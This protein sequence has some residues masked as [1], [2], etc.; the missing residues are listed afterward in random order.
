MILEEIKNIKSEKRDLRNFGITFGVVL[1]LI[2]GLLWWKEKDTYSIFIILSFTFFFFGFVLPALLK[3]LQK[4]WMALAVVLG[5]FMTKVIL[6]ILF[7]VVFTAIGLG[8]RL[9]GKQF[10][11]LKIDGSEKSYW[12]C[13][14]RESFDKSKYEKQ[15]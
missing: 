15:F 3:P 9:F 12:K 5:F 8:L 4:A 1:G 7:Y 11:D 10:L 14:E 6:S 13:R 2:G